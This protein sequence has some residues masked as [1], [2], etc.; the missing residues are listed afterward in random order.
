[1]AKPVEQNLE[2]LMVVLMESR[3]LQRRNQTKKQKQF[4]LTLEHLDSAV[5]EASQALGN[6][7]DI[8]DK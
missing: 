6:F 8:G 3:S 1:M 2:L 7:L 4:L 5:P